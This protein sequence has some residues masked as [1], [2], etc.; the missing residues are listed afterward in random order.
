MTTTSSRYQALDFYM[1]RTPTLPCQTYDEAGAFAGLAERTTDPIVREAIA[2]ASPTLLAAL[3][4]L[5][6]PGNPR[7]Q[8]QTLRSVLR[9]LNR[10]STRA[11][12]FGLFSGVG[13][14]T[15]AA[16]TSLRLGSREQFRKRSR[17]D[18]QWLLQIVQTLEQNPAVAVQLHVQ[19]NGMAY[20][21]GNRLKLPYV[22]RLGL[23]QKE[24]ET[25]SVRYSDALGWVLEQ[26]AQ[27]VR[28]QTLAERVRLQY[29]DVAPETV[30]RFL[31]QLFE[32]EYLLS[33]L[34]PSTT[35][36]DPFASFLDAL[37]GIGGIEELRDQLQAIH[38]KLRAYDALPL[39]AGEA[40]YLELVE[41]M[42]A[43][44]ESPSPLQV[45][46]A[47]AEQEFRLHEGIKA[48][49]EK[50]ADLLWRLS[51]LRQEPPHLEQLRGEFLE[52]YGTAR[53]VPLLELLDE[54]I[55]LGMPATYENPS[56]YRQLQPSAESK[57]RKA[58]E[59]LLLHWLL[60]AVHAQE[61]ELVLTD[62][63]IAELEPPAADQELTEPAPSLELYFHLAASSA[64]SVDD[65]DYRLVLGPN[66]GSQG[67][68]KTFGRFVDLLGEECLSRMEEIQDREQRLHPEK[69][70][71]EIA[72]LPHSGRS[73]NVVLTRSA[74][75]Y[76]IPVGTYSSREES[77]SLPLQDL[78]VGCRD[79]A[80]YLKSQRL[81]REVVPVT[82]HMLNLNAAPNVYRFLREI[83]TQ[84]QRSWSPFPWTSLQ[85]APYLPRVRYG[86]V[87]LSPACWKLKRSDLAGL[88]LQ[89]WRAKWGVPRY[90]Y[91]TEADNRIL[92]DFENALHVEEVHKQ[93]QSAT[94]EV[95]LIERIGALEEEIVEGEGG[96]YVNE[97]VFPL[98]RVVDKPAVVKAPAP[99]LPLIPVEKRA[100][101]PG[102]EWLYVKL[103][104]G[105]T[106]QEELIGGPLQAFMSQMQAS[107][108]VDKCYF[109]R[110]ADPEPHVRLRLQG[111]PQVLSAS[112]LPALSQ[113]TALQL[114]DGLIT[115]C[116]LDTYEPEIE[117]Y[118]GVD[119]MKK[120]E[121]LF[122]ADS[123]VMAEWIG[124]ARYGK[125]SLTLDQL[126]VLNVLHGLESFGLSFSEQF[127][128]M[129][130]NFFVK[131]HLE[132]F[133]AQR[134]LLL[135]IGNAADDWATLRAHP[136]GAEL[137]A[138]L[139]TREPLASEYVQ[140]V[141]E[142]ERAG[143]L[144]NRWEDILFSVI[145]LSMNRLL[146]TD[147]ARERKLM[148]LA[149][150]TLNGLRH[151]REVRR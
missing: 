39:G 21:H 88:D 3:P 143:L 49:V 76:E 138:S 118:G 35:T 43:L 67:A 100:F 101:L 65:G 23:N 109:L 37:Q 55:G 26:A 60:E 72:Y 64:Q 78:V 131:E 110:Y 141:Q 150:H 96:V 1:V 29:P 22:T 51:D 63:R 24:Y 89:A 45:D 149:R 20:R 41:Q 151:F 117:R 66:A 97:L 90:V 120:V 71:A 145:H 27:P 73:T 14:G 126:G 128:R 121:A 54:E 19:A 32:Q 69:V 2:V 108:W 134:S 48:D 104:G 115:R 12:P 93:V 40:L 11:T 130:A 140:A 111:D 79:G 9:Y 61:R 68:G 75:P 144:T 16:Q 25:V 99:V 81:H 106:R 92:I 114:Q 42:K 59:Q 132:E 129:D 83:S 30:Q 58:K 125:T 113:W 46:L 52:K 62:E 95:R 38:R 57:E 84:G 147:R 148:I 87:I 70:F 94:A 28:F 82:G 107:G 6:Q 86:R 50:A 17:P 122:A 44:A 15:F 8:E 112:V 80:F 10:M 142:Q 137:L 119:L 133:R 4:N 116:S 102:S 33:E 31:H 5:A 135:Q 7:K 36:P 91:L 98:V 18:M 53:E 13:Q 139:L 123:R 85:S 127:A 56:G 34:R 74:R 47:L 103:Y 124:K 77:R 105:K 146:G 136:E